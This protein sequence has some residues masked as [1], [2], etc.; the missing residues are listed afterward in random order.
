MRE[1]DILWTPSTGVGLEHLRLMEDSSGYVAS[2]VVIV[3]E[4]EQPF[5][6]WYGIRCDADW[7]VQSVD[8]QL[9]HSG[10][11]DTKIALIADGKGHWRLPSGQSLPALDGCVDVDITATPFTNTL[12]IRRLA[13]S[14]GQ[15]AEL[16]MAYI[17]VP[18]MEVQPSRQRYTCL[19]Q[20]ESGGL[21]RYEGLST[22]F[23]A[24]ILV[25]AD[26]LVIDYKG[27]F[28]RVW[29]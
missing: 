21:Y 9:F 22:G 14:P 13:F 25:D 20:S 10:N 28:R 5:S 2:S 3:V 17:I 11:R 26:G 6:I 23:T 24:E 15:S 12:P 29:A 1:R 16:L 19:E 8:V 4:D 27:L 7:G 18:E